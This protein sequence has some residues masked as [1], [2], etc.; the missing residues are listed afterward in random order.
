MVGVSFVPPSFVCLC[1]HVVLRPWSPWNFQ[2]F[3]DFMFLSQFGL[4]LGVWMS[5]EVSKWLVNGL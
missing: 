3:N 1:L 4:G 2:M 5:Q